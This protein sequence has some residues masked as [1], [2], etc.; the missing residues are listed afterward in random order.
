MIR[1]MRKWHRWIAVTVG[2]FFLIWLITGIAMMM[3]RLPGEHS[4]VGETIIPDFRA[5]SISPKEAIIALEAI[6]GNPLNIKHVRF[7]RILEGLAYQIELKD[8]RSYLINAQSAEEMIINEDRAKQIVKTIHPSKNI[9]GAEYVEGRP[10]GC[11]WGSFPVYKF[12]FDDNRQT[13][14]CVTVADGSERHRN[15]WQRIRGFSQGFHTFDP[16]N[17]VTGVNGVREGLLIFFSILGSVAACTGF[18]LAFNRRRL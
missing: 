7:I 6:Q 18:Y 5:V 2:G 17:L 13:I 1:Q 3:P 8:R 11:G 4:D 14:S 15:M 10:S 16:V 12:W 9:L